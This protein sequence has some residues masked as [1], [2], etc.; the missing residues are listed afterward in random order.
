MVTVVG[1]AKA[2]QGSLSGQYAAP[3]L[4]GNQGALF[5]G[6]PNGPNTSVSLTSGST[7]AGGA[8]RLEFGSDHQFWYQGSFHRRRRDGTGP[9][10]GQCGAGEGV[11]SRAGRASRLPGSRMPRALGNMAMASTI[12]HT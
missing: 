1:D 6:H 5:D 8:V 9:I 4:S 12:I 7:S 2:V 10:P 11:G 3:F